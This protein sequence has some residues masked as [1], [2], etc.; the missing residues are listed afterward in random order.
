MTNMPRAAG[1]GPGD[2]PLRRSP[3]HVL[4]VVARFY[5]DIADELLTGARA[6][7]DAAGATH[8]VVEVP[9]ALEIPQVL[10][11]A[12]EAFR[13]AMDADDDDDCLSC[14][15][16][17]DDD[18]DDG[19]AADTDDEADESLARACDTDDA[20]LFDG[21]VILGCVIR[22]E[23]AHFDIVCQNANH[24]A[25]EIATREAVPLGNGILTV[26]TSDQAFARAKG[27]ADGKGGDA[28]RA[29]LRLIAV[30]D[31]FSRLEARSG[32]EA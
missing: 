7:L 6:V 17:D 2:A 9:G 29:C 8:D 31:R 3:P 16:D 10:G 4:I 32:D 14:D 15:L 24:W 5:E 13:F 30:R 22:G 19:A 25:M 21:A 28:A 18:E 12:A 26:D 20:R 11:L 27:G 1:S 23:T